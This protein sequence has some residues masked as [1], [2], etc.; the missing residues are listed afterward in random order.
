MCT[1]LSLINK[2]F[3][4]NKLSTYRDIIVYILVTD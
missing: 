3:F 4:D 2:Y 1:L